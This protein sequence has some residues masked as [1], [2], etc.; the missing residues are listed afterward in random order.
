MDDEMRQ[1]Y[2]LINSV[3]MGVLKTINPFWSVHYL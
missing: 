1:S 2:A 3:A